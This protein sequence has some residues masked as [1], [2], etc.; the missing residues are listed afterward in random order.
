MA[1]PDRS[2]MISRNSSSYILPLCLLSL[3][4]K[5]LILSSSF[6]FSVQPGSPAY[7]PSDWLLYSLGDWF[8]RTPLG[9]STT[10]SHLLFQTPFKLSSCLSKIVLEYEYI[11]IYIYM[12]SVTHLGNEC[13]ASKIQIDHYASY[14]FLIVEGTR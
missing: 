4:Q 3:F 13:A 10:K 12:S 8:T 5:S 1:N 11:C 9:P 7:L 14:F 2:A 6:S